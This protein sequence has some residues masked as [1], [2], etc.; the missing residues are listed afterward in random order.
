MEFKPKNLENIK[1]A[2]EREI[3]IPKKA[4]ALYEQSR[5]QQTLQA[6]GYSDIQFRAVVNGKEGESGFLPEFY[7]H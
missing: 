4:S 5:I 1:K 7:S 2:Y 6:L 3:K